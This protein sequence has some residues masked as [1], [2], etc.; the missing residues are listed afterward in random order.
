M[1]VHGAPIV[2]AD[3]QV[4]ADGVG[5][6]EHRTGEVDADEARVTGDALQDSLPGEAP[7]D[8]IR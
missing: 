5:P 2:E 8:P 1:G 7:I 4:F 3:Q 6:D